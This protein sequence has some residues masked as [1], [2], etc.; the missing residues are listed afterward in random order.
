ME[1]PRLRVK[2]E[3]QLLAAATATTTATQYLS[4][5]YDLYYSSRQCRI[6]N[7]LSG[8]RDQTLNLMVPSRIHFR[9]A[10]TGTPSLVILNKRIF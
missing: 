2:L 7:V 5:I 9:C 4:H 8:A 10:M 1:V 3:L 6:L